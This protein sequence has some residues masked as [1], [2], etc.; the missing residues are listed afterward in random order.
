[1]ENQVALITK[2]HEE[3]EQEQV[4]ENDGDNDLLSVKEQLHDFAETKAVFNRQE[5][6]TRETEKM[7]VECQRDLRLDRQASLRQS[8]NLDHFKDRLT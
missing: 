8:S 5:K 1:M 3:R 2:S 6:L 4:R 7:I